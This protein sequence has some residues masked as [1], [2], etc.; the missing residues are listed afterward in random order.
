MSLLE[1]SQGHIEDSVKGNKGSV[2][3]I[4]SDRLDECAE[5]KKTGQVFS[6][7]VRGWLS[8]ASIQFVSWFSADSL[9]RLVC[10]IVAFSFEP[11]FSCKII[12]KFQLDETTSYATH[13]LA[14]TFIWIYIDNQKMLF[15]ISRLINRLDIILTW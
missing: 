1:L 8:C 11:F 5:E 12:S 10:T 6:T 15:V 13:A 4:P 2:K 3:T 7:R 14:H 9:C